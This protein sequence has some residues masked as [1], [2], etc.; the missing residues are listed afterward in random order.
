MIKESKTM[1]AQKYRKIK[2]V[3]AAIYVCLAVA[4]LA[5]AGC[6]SGPGNGPGSYKQKCATCS[7][8][9][10]VQIPLPGGGYYVASDQTDCC[11][12]ACLSLNPGNTDASAECQSECES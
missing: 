6:S 11:N 10:K 7:M 2:Q 3:T 4:S 1:K 9:N 12:Q 5:Y 8:E